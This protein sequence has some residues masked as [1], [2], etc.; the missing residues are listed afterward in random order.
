MGTRAKYNFSPEVIA[1]AAKL[2][3]EGWTYR[4]LA[5]KFGGSAPL[6][7]GKLDPKSKEKSRSYYEN[8]KEARIEAAKRRYWSDPDAKKVRD[9]VKK[10]GLTKEEV[11]AM[12][13]TTHC[14]ICGV[15]LTKDTTNTGMAIDHC[16][17]TGK[18]RGV[19][20]NRCNRGLGFFSDNI[21]I[22]HQAI[23]YLRDHNG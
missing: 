10:Y 4:Q 20:C 14:Q 15:E 3:E 17:D 18:V 16:H 6:W 9:R 12:M 19:L 11:E 13:G 22:L 2:K 1:E 7:H 23:N 5:D 8:N 21:N